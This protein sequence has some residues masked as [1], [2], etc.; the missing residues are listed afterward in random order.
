MTYLGEWLALIGEDRLT[1]TLS[2]PHCSIALAISRNRRRSRWLPDL[3][4]YLGIPLDVLLN[5]DPSAHNL[6]D[7]IRKIRDE[8]IA[9]AAKRRLDDH[10][11]RRAAKAVP[12]TLAD[13]A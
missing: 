2:I 6:P 4:G 9:K 1:Y 11:A 3:A 7:H 5:V 10:L 8:A 12:E 13:A